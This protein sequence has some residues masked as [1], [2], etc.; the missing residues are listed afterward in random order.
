[1][2]H[3]RPLAVLAVLALSLLV[4]SIAQAALV[5]D[6][7]STFTD[8]TG[9]SGQLGNQLSCVA[10]SYSGGTNVTV[11][12][13]WERNGAIV[14]TGSAPVTLTTSDFGA[15]FICHETATNDEGDTLTASS[16]PIT[17]VEPPPTLVTNPSVSG[18]I[19]AGRPAT[20]AGAVFDGYN[21]GAIS[22]LWTKSGAGEVSTQ[23]T[24]TP[25]RADIGWD[26][27]C[28][29]TVTNP[30]GSAEGYSAQYSVEDGTPN[31]DVSPK[32][33]GK[34][35]P[36]LA[37]AC[38]PGKWSGEGITYSYQWLL[39]DKPIAG[40]ITTRLIVLD[41]FVEKIIKCRV[42]ATNASG[43]ASQVSNGVA[44]FAPAI[45]APVA[46]QQPA[47]P[48]LK[49]ALAKGI[50]SK[51]VC[52]G[53]CATEA[54]AFILAT[55]AA[56]LGI[57]GRNLGGVMVIGTGS[58]KR[59]YKGDLLVTTVFSASAKKGLAKIRKPIR[60]DLLFE[61]AAGSTYSFKKYHV[62]TSRSVM[63]RR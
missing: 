32:I 31:V 24:Y 9:W 13:R 45:L 43:S 48:K 54:H 14:C 28:R 52:N 34:G 51:V 30:G 33:T 41:R 26:L 17:L 40:A 15:T 50:T 44:G 57:R 7:P 22:Y 56:R 35:T 2:H 3:V 19:I 23:Q 27:S 55:D 63:L 21:M 29:A 8:V 10:S 20:C 47:T 25:T 18:T 38:T 61:T 49:V 5:R 6:T 60:I 59:T 36:G 62:A 58:A 1:M 46:K 4:P 16:L 11:T 39:G 42:T 53:S 37:L 12:T